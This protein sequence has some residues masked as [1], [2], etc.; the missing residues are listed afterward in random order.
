[1]K[2][3]VEIGRIALDDAY[4]H[5]I[6]KDIV[7]FCVSRKLEMKRDLTSAEITRKV[8]RYRMSR[9]QVIIGHCADYMIGGSRIV[10]QAWNSFCGESWSKQRKPN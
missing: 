1:M 3:C 4:R 7:M 8:L 5:L 6:C 10:S 2:V 9:G